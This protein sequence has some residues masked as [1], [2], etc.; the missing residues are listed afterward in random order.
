MRSVTLHTVTEYL[1]CVPHCDRDG[2]QQVTSRGGGDTEPAYKISPEPLPSLTTPPW[3]SPLSS[4]PRLPTTPRP[5]AGC[6]RPRPSVGSTPTKPQ[7]PPHCQIPWWDSLLRV[8]ELL[9]MS[10]PCRLRSFLDIPSSPVPCVSAPLRPS[11]NLS[12][13]QVSV[14][15]WK[16]PSSPTTTDPSFLAE[17]PSCDPAAASLSVLLSAHVA[18]LPTPCAAVTLH[19]QASPPNTTPPAAL[20]VPA[21]RGDPP[22][23]PGLLFRTFS[24]A[25]FWARSSP[26]RTLNLFTPERAAYP[27]SGLPPALRATVKLATLHCRRFCVCLAH[28]ALNFLRAE[29]MSHPSLY[30]QLLAQCLARK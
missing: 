25:T 15:P 28:Q 30:F 6:P 13:V 21:P 27:S 18:L 10:T 22:G 29:I 26:K 17:E 1:L 24:I 3:V 7:K 14:K 8:P 23:Q 5:T 19:P 11:T 9:R 20:C 16:P 12:N 2:G 4:L